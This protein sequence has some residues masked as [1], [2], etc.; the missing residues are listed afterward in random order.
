M[1]SRIL[2]GI[3]KQ[4]DLQEAGPED[5]SGDGV[6]TEEAERKQGE[7]HARGRSSKGSYSPG[8]G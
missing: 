2:N 7:E 6:V 8:T 5:R 3:T 1:G 4:R